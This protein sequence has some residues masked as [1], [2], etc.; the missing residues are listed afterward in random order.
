[1]KTLTASEGQELA[2][3]TVAT[4]HSLRT[5]EMYDLFW[6]KVTKMANDLE[7]DPPT[8]PRSHKRPKR[9]ENGSSPSHIHHTPQHYFH[10]MYFEALDLATNSITDRFD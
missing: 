9:Y 8:L 3:L 1:M 6:Q 5:D 4:L 10:S 2:K 7:V